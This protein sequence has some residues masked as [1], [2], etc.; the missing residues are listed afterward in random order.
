MADCGDVC[1]AEVLA[2]GSDKCLLPLPVTCFAS[3]DVGLKFAD[4]TTP[5][6]LDPD[7]VLLRFA[8]AFVTSLP[9]TFAVTSSRTGDVV[10]A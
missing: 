4:V 2:V 10:D 7:T 5:E 8:A 6:S 9:L 1:R 3:G